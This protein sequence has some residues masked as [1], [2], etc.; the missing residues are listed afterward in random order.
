VGGFKAFLESRYGSE[1]APLVEVPFTIEMDNGFQVRGRIDAVYA[2]GRAWEI[3]DFK[4]G[5]RRDDPARMVQLQAY[6]VAATKVDFGLEEP[7]QIDVSFVYLGGGLEV[8][9]ER[10]DGQWQEQARVNLERLTDAIDGDR[11]EPVPGG[12]CNGCDF[13]RFCPEGKCEVGAP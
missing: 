11:F 2:R 7:E 6:S 4:S 13:L 5:K 1:Q 12:W 3:V 10:A 8:H 9:T